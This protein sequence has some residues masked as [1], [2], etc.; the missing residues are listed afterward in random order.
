VNYVNVAFILLFPRQVLMYR[1]DMYPADMYL[2]GDIYTGIRHLKF[3]S[4]ELIMQQVFVYG[5]CPAWQHMRRSVE[6]C[7]LLGVVSC[8][9]AIGN[10]CNTH[11]LGKSAWVTCYYTKCSLHFYCMFNLIKPSGHYVPHSGHYM[12]GTVV[13]I[14]TAQWSLY[15]SHSG[16]YMYHTVVTICSA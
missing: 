10:S 6:D 5:S 14:Y 1:A 16:H 12:Y 2:H 15:V 7:C 3:P 4:I 8:L 9:F 13:T 11:I